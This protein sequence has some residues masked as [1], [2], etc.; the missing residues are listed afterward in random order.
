MLGALYLLSS[1]QFHFA[2]PYISEVFLQLTILYSAHHHTTDIIMRN[3]I[4]A[5]HVVLAVNTVKL[6][7]EARVN[8][9]EIINL[10]F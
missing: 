2:I 5:Q 7:A 10:A 8:I 9:Q 6:Q 4:V 3:L 1:W